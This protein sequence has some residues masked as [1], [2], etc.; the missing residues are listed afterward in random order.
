M[1]LLAILPETFQDLALLRR[2]E[3]SDLTIV[4]SEDVEALRRE[5][6]DADAIV[7]RPRHAQIVREI[8]PYAKRLRWIHSIAAGVETLLFDELVHSDVVV[9]NSRGLF[10]D[11]LA[12]FVVAAILWFAKDLRRLSL[13]QRQ[14]HWE[15]Y[16]VQRIEGR[17]LGIIGYGGIGRAVA[18]RA[19]GMGMHVIATRRRSELASG[20]AIVGRMYDANEIDALI[21]ESSYLVLSTPLTASTYRL[22]NAAR[23]RLM[24][25]DA[26]LINVGRGEVVDQ[27]ALAG[28]LRERRIHG[29]ALDVFEQEPL[30]PDDPLWTLDNVLI[31]PHT[32]D[33]TSDSHARSMAFFLEQLTRFRNGERLENVVDKVERY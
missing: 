5:V 13:N 16:T 3:S 24:R 25:N 19:D 32:A 23:L 26:V 7:L 29:A 10:A 9:T 8:F 22:M 14:H 4:V 12:E 28:A 1:K 30:P 20:D 27:R 18:R 33:H 2:Q 15:P 31:S 17:T 21:A 11:A 6:V